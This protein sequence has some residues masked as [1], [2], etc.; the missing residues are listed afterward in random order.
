MTLAVAGAVQGRPATTVAGLSRSLER[1]RLVNADL[2]SRL[3][4]ERRDSMD[5]AVDVRARARRVH[6][7]TVADRADLALHE[8]S[9]VVSAAD[10]RI[11]Q[12]EGD[13]R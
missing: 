13:L 5:F 8:A 7:A 1:A 12:L 9:A 4:A 3:L 2:R 10:R 11:R 6:M